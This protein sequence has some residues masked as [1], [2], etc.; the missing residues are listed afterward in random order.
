MS[1]EKL[2][3][4]TAEEALEIIN[5]NEELLTNY[6]MIKPYY[7]AGELDCSFACGN[8]LTLSDDP[9]KISVQWFMSDKQTCAGTISESLEEALVW[10]QA[11]SLAEGDILPVFGEIGTIGE[12]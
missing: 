3:R 7:E 4:Y 6:N 5:Q 11:I 8:F 2:K 9:S 10:V 1:I 12:Y